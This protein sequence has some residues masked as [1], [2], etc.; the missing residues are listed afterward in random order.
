MKAD[1]QHSTVCWGQV[2][3]LQCAAALG[4]RGEKESLPRLSAGSPLPEVELFLSNKRGTR[5]LLWI[6]VSG[7]QKGHQKKQ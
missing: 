3:R 5:K 6:D 7:K 1:L 4:D 2:A